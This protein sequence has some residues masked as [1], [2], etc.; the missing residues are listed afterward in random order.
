MDIH[1]L[2]YKRDRTGRIRTWYMIADPENARYAFDTGLK[3]GAR[4]QSGWTT[5]TGKQGRTAA[6]QVEFEV[7]SNYRHQLE[8]DYFESEAEVDTPRITL[9]MLAQKYKAFAPGYVQPKLDGMRCIAKATGLFSRQGKPIE[10][11]PHIIE[12]LAPFFEKFPDAILDGELYNHDYAHRFEELMSMCRKSGKHLTPE[13][14]EATKVVQY[15]VYD[16]P[17]APGGFASRW[18]QLIDDLQVVVLNFTRFDRI[19][20]VPTFQVLVEDQVKNFLAEFLDG[21]YEGLIWRDAEGEYIFDGRPKFLQK[22]TIKESAEFP[23]KELVLGNGNWAGVPKSATVQLED[24][25]ECDVSIAGTKEQC[26]ALLEREQPAYATV[27][28]KGRTAYGKLRCGVV[29]D[30]HGREGR[31][32]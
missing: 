27:E 16:Y 13:I 8:R 20:A 5:V 1:P 25:Q 29:K 3:D 24:G 30:W 9:P 23:V 7:T 32:D 19:W 26:A 4:T 14:L 17:S 28:F 31:Q 18:H 12:A 21:D 22:L 11:V 6:E 15:H 2:L 10:A